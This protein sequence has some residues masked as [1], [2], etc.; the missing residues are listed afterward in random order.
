MGKAEIRANI[1]YYRGQRNK[2]RGKIAKLRNARI[3][4]YQTSTTVQKEFFLE[5]IDRKISQY[6]TSI[7]SYDRSIYM[8]QEAL[9]MA[10][11]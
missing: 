8:L 4:L 1:S 10:D 9:A 11:D 6:E 7:A 3:R 2:L 5:E